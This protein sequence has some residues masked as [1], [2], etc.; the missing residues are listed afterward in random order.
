MLYY[1]DRIDTAL[2]SGVIQLKDARRG[3]HRIL[4]CHWYGVAAKSNIVNVFPIGWGRVPVDAGL[5]GSAT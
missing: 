3:S 5:A 1:I 4:F 2:P